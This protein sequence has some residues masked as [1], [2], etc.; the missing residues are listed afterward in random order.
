[1]QRQLCF[2]LGIAL[3]CVAAVLYFNTNSRNNLDLRPVGK[4]EALTVNGGGVPGASFEIIACTG[5]Y[6]CNASGL[7]GNG[8]GNQIRTGSKSCGGTCNPALATNLEP[9]PE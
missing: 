1:M 7:N 4:V 5:S 9:A 3:F 8:P 2:G 6:G